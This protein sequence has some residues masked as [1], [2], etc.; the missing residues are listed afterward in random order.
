MTIEVYLGGDSLTF[1]AD[2]DETT[3]QPNG[4]TLLQDALR[5]HCDNLFFVAIPGRSSDILT[6]LPTPSSASK[7]VLVINT[8]TNDQQGILYTYHYVRGA[9]ERID[10]D[11]LVLTTVNET[12]AYGIDGWAPAINAWFRSGAPH[13]NGFGKVYPFVINEWANA[14]VEHPEWFLG[15]Q[16]HHNADGRAAWRC[17]T[18]VWVAEA[19]ERMGA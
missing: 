19:I 8:G 15:D 5:Q 3:S 13:A 4:R 7:R 11:Y 9:I 6:M 16:T 18:T 1:Q 12:P 10:P 14:F 2:V 17:A